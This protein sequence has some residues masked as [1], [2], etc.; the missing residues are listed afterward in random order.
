[1]PGRADGRTFCSRCLA[2]GPWAR[3]RCCRPLGQEAK[4]SGFDTHAPW[5]RPLPRTA[6]CYPAR[7][8][9]AVA[10]AARRAL[11]SCWSV[12]CR[13]MC[14]LLPGGSNW[15]LSR[16]PPGGSTG[17]SSAH[18]AST[19][20]PTGA[21]KSPPPSI[22]PTGPVRQNY[23]CVGVYTLKNCP[24]TQTKGIG[25]ERPIRKWPAVQG[26]GLLHR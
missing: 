25:C 2:C 26:R 15:N 21:S 14:L 12:K 1:M 18:T 3:G 16:R 5:P 8:Q 7:P 10:H 17:S 6:D 19:Q 9:R 20:R 11:R 22:R 13:W 4:K 23:E 24:A